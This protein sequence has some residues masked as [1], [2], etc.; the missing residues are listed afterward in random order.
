MILLCYIDTVF[1]QIVH[2][3]L[4][5]TLVNLLTSNQQ[6]RRAVFWARYCCSY[7]TRSFFSIMENR[8]IG[9]ADDS[10][11]IAVVPFPGIIV[12]M[13]ESLSRDIVKVSQWCDLSGMKFNASKTETMIVSRSSTMS[14]QSPVLTIA[15]TVLNESEDLVILGVTFDSNLF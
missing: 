15:E 9:Y 1:H 6:C 8:L 4:W 2:S 13:A 12:A 3:T 10:T 7:T 5:W 14:L 11:V